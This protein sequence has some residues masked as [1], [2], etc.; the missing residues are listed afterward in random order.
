MN[1][2]VQGGTCWR[3]E[4]VVI[5]ILA[6]QV[7]YLDWVGMYVWYL[8]ENIHANFKVTDLSDAPASEYHLS[9]KLPEACQAPSPIQPKHN[10][11]L[12]QPTTVTRA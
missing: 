12:N 6:T 4:L 3:F 9:L 1:I 7:F 8:R 2:L 11:Y 5:F 10:S